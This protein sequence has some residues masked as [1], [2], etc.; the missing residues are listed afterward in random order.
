LR[1][2]VTGATGLVGGCLVPLLVRQG[3]EVHALQR[4]TSRGG[5]ANVHVHVGEA[6]SWPRLVRDIAPEAA[7]SC[8]GTTMRK[9]GSEAAF[10]AVDRDMVLSFAAAARAAGARRMLTI[11]SAGASAGSANF[12]L[13]LKAEVDGALEALGF[14]RLDIFRPGLLRGP[15]GGDRRLG[16]RIGVALSPLLN[17][18]LRGWLDRYAAIDALLVARSMAAALG[19][20]PSGV[21]VHENR[22]IRRL[23]AAGG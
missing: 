2:A 22:A 20:N 17:L 3:H 23:A 12:Y 6:E 10:A 16:E 19:A 5:N 15:R 18:A 4:R 13:K 9:A 1:A 11:S 8:L 7:V 14:E 21:F